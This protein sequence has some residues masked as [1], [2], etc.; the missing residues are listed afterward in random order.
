MQ[1]HG[2]LLVQVQRHYLRRIDLRDKLIA[3]H[4][5]ALLKDLVS[6]MSHPAA[7]LLGELWQHWEIYRPALV[8]DIAL[9][10][11]QQKSL[12]SIFTV[13]IEKKQILEMS[14]L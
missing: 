3:S 1:Y 9:L 6:V 11:C 7:S 10:S 5:P 12:A 8:N 13:L 4:D 14:P 2:D